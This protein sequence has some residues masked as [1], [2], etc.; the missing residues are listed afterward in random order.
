MK[1]KIS[2]LTLLIITFS[3]NTYAYKQLK[4]LIDAPQ[5]FK[6]IPSFN[7]FHLGTQTSSDEDGFF[8]LPY[9]AD[10]ENFSVLI[11]RNFDTD[12]DQKNTVKGLKID[13]KK[14][15]KF[16]VDSTDVE[17]KR[18]WKLKHLYSDEIPQ[19]TLIIRMNPKLVKNLEFW[20]LNLPI[21]LIKG[22]HIVLNTTISEQELKK[23]SDKSILY[24][25][26]QKPFHEEVKTTKKFFKDKKKK[27]S[28]SN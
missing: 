4:G 20:N 8:S 27:V 11:S 10:N 2:I 15:Y 25:L 6:N 23:A 5:K 7:I 14:P 3:I 19:N 9:K 18:Y 16:F 22:P 26:N 12:K 13:T 21:N 1:F 17:G 24:S 28:I